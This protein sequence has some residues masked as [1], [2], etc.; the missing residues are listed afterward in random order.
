MFKVKYMRKKSDTKEA[1]I[2]PVRMEVPN[3]W[4][5]NWLASSLVEWPP[6]TQVVG[7]RSPAETCLSRGTLLEDGENPGQVSP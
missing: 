5:N 4:I 3:S 2:T 1:K 7:V 6:A